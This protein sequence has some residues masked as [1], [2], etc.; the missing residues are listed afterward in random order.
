MSWDGPL[1]HEKTTAK[2]PS[3]SA[4]NPSPVQ[5][6]TELRPPADNQSSGRDQ[7]WTHPPWAQETQPQ[8]C[9]SIMTAE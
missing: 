2:E 6:M 3:L 7:E 9:F 1:G 8:R 5:Q 4:L